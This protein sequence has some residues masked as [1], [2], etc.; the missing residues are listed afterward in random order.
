LTRNGDARVLAVDDIVSQLGL[1]R[2]E[3][4]DLVRRGHLPAKRIGSRVFVTSAALAAYVAKGDHRATFARFERGQVVV[5]MD[6]DGSVG[7]GWFVEET[8]EGHV[9]V[10]RRGFLGA[11]DQLVYGSQVQAF[12]CRMPA[13]LTH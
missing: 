13:E 1:T 2:P 3:V 11:Y 7:V 9:R 8:A 6:P 5:V 12:T 4:M 10:R